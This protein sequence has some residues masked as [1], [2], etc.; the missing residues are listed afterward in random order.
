MPLA[1]EHAEAVPGQNDVE[2]SSAGDALE[3]GQQGR[4]PIRFDLAASDGPDPRVVPPE[5]P[6]VGGEQSVEQRVAAPDVATVRAAGL[7][8]AVLIPAH[9]PGMGVVI[10]AAEPVGPE[11]VGLVPHFVE[12]GPEAGHPQGGGIRV[13]HRPRVTVDRAGELDR[14]PRTAETPA[15]AGAPAPWAPESVS[16][17]TRPPSLG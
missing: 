1:P 3:D 8:E 9:G 15:Q 13:D 5:P 6:A 11:L 14:P 10:M 7:H 2:A 4:R 12:R 16:P 17:A